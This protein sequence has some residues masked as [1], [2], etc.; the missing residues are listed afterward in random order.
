MFTYRERKKSIWGI[1]TKN[2]QVKSRLKKN[3]NHSEGQRKIYIRSK[4][5]RGYYIE[6]ISGEQDKWRARI[7]GEFV[8]GSLEQIKMSIDLW[9]DRKEFVPPESIRVPLKSDSL[10]KKPRVKVYKGVKIFIDDEGDD[11]WYLIYKG[12]LLK[13]NLPNI[14]SFIDKIRK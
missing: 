3:P 11:E 7:N 10:K 4:Y 6:S 1:F 12:K 2:V 8:S 14:V 9:C 13:G 5:H